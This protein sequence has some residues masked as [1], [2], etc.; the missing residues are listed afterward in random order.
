MGDMMPQAALEVQ[1]GLGRGGGADETFGEEGASGLQIGLRDQGPRA[2]AI[3]HWPR[4]KLCDRRLAHRH[5]GARGKA[6]KCSHLA[7]KLL[8]RPAKLIL[9]FAGHRRIAELGLGALAE[10]CDRIGQ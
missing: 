4:T 8:E 7:D 9:R 3:Q 2:D 1:A 6:A 5:D 10:L